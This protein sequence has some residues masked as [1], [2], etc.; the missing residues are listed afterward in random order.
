MRF[1]IKRFL[2]LTIFVLILPL[3][4]FANNSYINDY[5][6]D[7][8]VKQNNVYEIDEQIQYNFG[9]PSHGFYRTLYT[10]GGENNSV[11]VSN[12]QSSSP[13][14]SIKKT[15]STVS[16]II[17]DRNKSVSGLNVYNI[18]YSYDVGEDQY[19]GFDVFYFNLIGTEWNDPIRRFSFRI[20]FPDGT[21]I[22]KN[23]IQC[24]LG[25]YG[26]ANSSNVD[27]VVNNNVISGSL[28]NI[29]PYTALTIL[30]PLE[31]GY[32]V[33]ARKII[34]TEVLVLIAYSSL[35]LLLLVITLVC[36]F[37]CGRERMLTPVV[38]AYPSKGYSPLD[39][40][41]LYKKGI[42]GKAI[43]GAI[44]NFS[45]KGYLS[46]TYNK[47]DK[48]FSKDEIILKKIRDCDDTFSRE[49][50]MLFDGLFKNDCVVNTSVPNG[51]FQ[52]AVI[53]LNSS[54]KALYNS[55]DR[56]IY[57]KK[58]RK[59][60]NVLLSCITIAG[61]LGIYV[62]FK[63][64][65]GSFTGGLFSLRVGSFIFYIVSLIVVPILAHN[66]KR[67]SEYY[68][69]MLE[70]ILGL[71]DFIVTVEKDRI[72]ML[73]DSDPEF[74]YK[75]LSYAIP[76]DVE[77]K[78]AK[79]FDGLNIKPPQYVNGNCNMGDMFM[80]MYMS[81]MMNNTIMMQNLNNTINSVTRNNL[82]GGI[83]MGGGGLGGGFSGGGFGG[84]GGGRW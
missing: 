18:S 9:T 6:I 67:R 78:W 28:N 68:S 61:F 37:K 3:Y 27:V 50:K 25:R 22:D 17:G 36:Y 35:L 13:I 10:R 72:K 58:S 49:E 24:F 39:V 12:F 44:L 73:L 26:E 46:I 29:L 65:I 30:L 55:G 42:D 21:K 2:L 70:K 83:N 84:G 14:D 76:L 66:V 33:G 74:F 7:I 71:K 19:K 1:F 69:S 47:K 80:F 57:D 63:V 82:G 4:V 34:K 32:F 60:S 59:I 53:G 23:D 52:K 79:K 54:I 45:Q 56:D 40:R 8:K 5:S 41:Y 16:Y 51:D 38:S 15:S 77:N 48:L 81:N 62:F 11:K 20:T 31:D 64:L 43:S 75:I